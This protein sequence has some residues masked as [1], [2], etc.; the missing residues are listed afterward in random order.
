MRL[1]YQVFVQIGADRNQR[2]IKCRLIAQVE[3]QRAEVARKHVDIQKEV[4]VANRRRLA[5]FRRG[6]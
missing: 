1:R 2:E 4:D 5:V 6:Y 3:Q